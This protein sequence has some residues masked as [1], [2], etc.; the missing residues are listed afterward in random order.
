M[1]NLCKLFVMLCVFTISAAAFSLT[2]TSAPTPLPIKQII[3]PKGQ[4]NINQATLSAL[5]QIKGINHNKAKN[6]LAYRAK[7]GPFK[8][9]D[10]LKLVTGFKKL[11]LENFKAIVAQFTI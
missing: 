4:I 5:L 8:N 7:H 2:G 9:L 1:Q 6:I 3:Q 10:E 11:K